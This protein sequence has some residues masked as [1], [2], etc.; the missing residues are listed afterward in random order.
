MANILFIASGFPPY[1]FSENIANGKLVLALLNSGHSVQVISKIDE[2]QTYN[3]EWREP[4]L[5]LK[6]IT[7]YISYPHGN[8]LT[9]SYEL[10]RNTFYFKYLQ[11]G[12]RWAGYAFL[13]AKEL[14]RNE[15]FDLLMTRSPSDIAHLVGLRLKKETNIRWIANLNDPTT[16]IWPD[17]YETN[18]SF[19]KKVVSRKFI[20]E[21]LDKADKISFPSDL[22]AEHF[23]AYFKIKDQSISIIPHIM[24]EGVIEAKA[25]TNRVGLHIIHSG[26]L[27][28]ERNPVNLLRAI[29]Q[30]NTLN[31]EKVYLDI[32]GVISPLWV[33]EIGILE[34]DKYVKAIEPVPYS[35]AMQKMSEYDVLLV[36]EAQVKK[37]VFLPSKIADYAQLKKPILAISPILGEVSNLF[38]ICGGGMVAYN[39]SVSDIYEKLAALSRLNSSKQLTEMVKS[40]TL[41]IYLG[42]TRLVNCLEKHIL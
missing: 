30:Y 13:K 36:I 21:V 7:H 23:K 8:K 6:P 4:W 5:P 12:I 16:G 11:E 33:D 37:G 9:R 3:S 39:R 17:P 22:L 38:E 27:S 25:D 18:L 32:L 2:G 42:E 1:E 26:N 28:I 34:L 10:I 14:L 24:L 31:A 41:H 19:W 15:H 20:Q 35:K 29:K 40:S